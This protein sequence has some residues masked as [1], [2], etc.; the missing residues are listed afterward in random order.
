M[1][2]PKEPWMG[3]CGGQGGGEGGRG[4]PHWSTVHSHIFCPAL[5]PVHFLFCSSTSLLA[6]AG[7][8][9]PE[10]FPISP[11]SS[12]DSLS[13]DRILGPSFLSLTLSSGFSVAFQHLSVLMR[14][15]LIITCFLRGPDP[16]GKKGR[17]RAAH[18]TSF[19]PERCSETRGEV[20]VSEERGASR[21]VRIS[22][23][24]ST[25]SSPRWVSSAW[26]PPPGGPTVVLAWSQ[27]L[28][29]SCLGL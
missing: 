26:P 21:A 20:G 27:G 11:S 3:C 17:G 10:S 29:S 13:G 22:P 18:A 23:K 7:E 16:S 6:L 12:K 5:L 24:C 15:L 9:K 19:L 25:R 4:A 1:G 28:D 8:R 14:H 2:K